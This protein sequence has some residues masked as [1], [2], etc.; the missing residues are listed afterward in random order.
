MRPTNEM[1]KNTF[2][3]LL[4]VSTKKCPI[5]MLLLMIS[6]GNRALQYIGCRAISRNRK[7]VRSIRNWR[8]ARVRILSSN[9]AAMMD[10][11]DDEHHQQIAEYCQFPR[12]EDLQV[13]E[14]PD[15]Q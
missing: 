4:L 8:K 5:R 11:T 6:K 14:F 1:M 7:I 9:P 2:E 13:E 10:G 3:L 12:L 15:S